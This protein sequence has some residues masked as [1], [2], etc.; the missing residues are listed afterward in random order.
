MAVSV[1]SAAPG[2]AAQTPTRAAARSHDELELL[3]KGGL[4]PIEALRTATINPAEFLHREKD[5][6]TVETGKLADLVLLDANPLQQ[7]TN[8]Q[9]I[10][11][12]VSNGRYLA[13]P[14]LRK[15]L[16]RAALIVKK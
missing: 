1:A 9:K 12:V 8:T 2:V 7:I 10:A 16:E 11:A 3:V 6:G 14:E 5:L 13:A 4:T 15:L